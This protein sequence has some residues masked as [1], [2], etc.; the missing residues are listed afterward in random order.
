[1]PVFDPF[2]SYQLIQISIVALELAYLL[3]SH[4]GQ[5]YQMAQC[6]G[7]RLNSITFYLLVFTFIWS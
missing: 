3:V 2:K 6:Q 4:Q 7:P 1:M 5:I